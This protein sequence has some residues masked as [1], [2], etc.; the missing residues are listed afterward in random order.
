MSPGKQ[1]PRKWA[2]GKCREIGRVWESDKQTSAK[3]GKCV[4]RKGK[5]L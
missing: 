3:S 1:P 4:S 5:S 2:S